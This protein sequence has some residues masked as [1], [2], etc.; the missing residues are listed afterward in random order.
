GR[1]EVTRYGGELVDGEVADVVGDVPFTVRL[2]DGRSLEARRLLIATGT[3]DGL[4][5][6]PGLAALWGRDVL[7][8]PYCHGWEARDKTIGVLA[9]APTSV[10][11][12]LLLRQ[13]SDEVTLF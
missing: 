11:E 8:C 10:D 5:Q 7:H 1:D 2:T 13:W 4:P 9:T 6:I 3:R 12:A